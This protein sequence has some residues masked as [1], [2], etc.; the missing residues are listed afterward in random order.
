M[1]FFLIGFIVG[2]AIVVF[3]LGR[4]V[5]KLDAKNKLLQEKY[6][7]VTMTTEEFEQKW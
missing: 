1:I 6:D 4:L 2:E 3:F 7:S 5:V